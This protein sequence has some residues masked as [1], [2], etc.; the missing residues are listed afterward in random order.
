MSS[1]RHFR[2]LTALLNLILVAILALSPAAA[3]PAFAAPRAALPLAASPAAASFQPRA[4]AQSSFQPDALAAPLTVVRSQSTYDAATAGGFITVT[5]TVRNNLP[6][7]DAPQLTPGANVTDTI[8][9]LTAFDY[10]RDPNRIRQVVLSDELLGGVASFVAADPQPSRNGNR[11]V[12]NLGDLDP[13][14]EA[15]IALRIAAPGSAANFTNLDSGAT[16]YGA[17]QG[18]M[19][20]AS[21]QPARL[22]PD[23]LAAFLGCTVDANCADPYVVEQAGRLGGDAVAAFEYVRD[24]VGFESYAGSLRGARG[25]LWS[26]AGNAADQASLLIALLRASG[27][28]ARYLRGTL[29][30]VN[31]QTLLASMFPAP[32]GVGGLAPAGEPAADPVNSAALLNPARSHWWV[33]AYLPGLGW[34][35]LDPSFASAS[36]G[37]SFTPPQGPP[38]AELPDSIRHKVTISLKV[39]QY[40]VFSGGP[41]AVG[42]S[43]IQP[44]S[45]T[46]A[47]VELVGEPVTLGHLVSTDT[48]GGMVFTN[49]EHT[50]VP[51]LVVGLE[52]SLY[53]GTPYLELL[54]NFPLAS[55]PILAQWLIFTLTAP[56][57]STQTYE[58]ELF[59]YVGYDAR[60]GGGAVSANVARGNQPVL[61]ESTQFTTLFAP[62]GV[63]PDALNRTYPAMVQAVLDGQ[64]ALEATDAIVAAGQYTPEDWAVL[65]A[66]RVTFGRVTR[67][68][69]RMSLL[70]FTAV[71]DYTSQAYGTAFQVKAYPD[72]PRI[73]T[74]AWEEE[75]TSGDGTLSMD[76]RRDALNVVPLSRPDAGRPAR[77]QQRARPVR[78]EPGVAD[79]GRDRRRAGAQ[80]G[81]DPGRGRGAKHPAGDDRRNAA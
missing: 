18:R 21:A 77:L 79:P 44:L 17:H 65:S 36:V 24:G 1:I 59:D 43:T 5:L 25:A 69:Q 34:T 81:R 60:Q 62:S 75:V 49:Y 9:A 6:P 50:Y 23:G 61:R 58:R 72:S 53:Q 57:G 7:L 42:L 78:D 56:N 63:S 11:L 48:A 70:R 14:G 8:A 28:P 38:V 68:A 74:V 40:N 13:Y 20:S 10:R 22:A 26:A 32:S 55:N 41:G 80:R 51:Y 29:S 31:A 64:A 35:Q 67:L 16:A 76:L 46:F 30:T 3:A 4:A 66:A 47:A 39:E 12:W 73:F 45:Q 27:V 54:T 15:S 71:S 33:E 2:P 37:Q 19:V 52:E